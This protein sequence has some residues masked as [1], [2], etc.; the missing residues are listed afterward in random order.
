MRICTL[1]YIN[2]ILSDE[3][4]IPYAFMEWKKEVPE[5]YFVGEYSETGSINEDGEQGI[6]FIVTGFTRG[7]WLSLEK[8]RSKIEEKIERT[9]ILDNGTGVAVFYGNALPVPTGDAEL[10]RI[11]INLTIK[12][13]KNGR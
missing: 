13:Y 3:L 7:S 9:A 10:K 5:V 6:Q 4:G 12:E 8:Y 2:S 11:Q 1:E